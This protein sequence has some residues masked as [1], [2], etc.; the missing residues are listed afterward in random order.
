[1]RSRS[2]I[3]SR[4]PPRA[5]RRINYSAVREAADAIIINSESLRSE[6]TQHLDVD[7]SKFR[8]IYEAVDHRRLQARRR[9]RRTG[10]PRGIRRH[11]AVRALRVVAVAVQELRRS[12]ARLGACAPRARQIISW[13]SSG[14]ARDEKYAARL[15]GLAAELG[16]LDDVVFTGG[17]PLEETVELLPGGR[18]LRVPVVQRDVRA[19]DPRGD[20]VRLPG[21]DVEH[22]CDA[23]DR[24]RR[25]PALRPDRSPPSIARGDRSTPQDRHRTGCA[26]SGSGGPRSSPGRDG[27]GDARR[28]PR[29]RRATTASARSM[30]IL[31]TGGAGFIGSH[32]CDRLARARARRRRARRV[33]AAGALATERRRYLVPTSTSTKATS[34]TATCLRI[35]CVV[36]TRSTTSLRTRTTFPDFSRFSDVNVVSTALIYEII[37]AERLDLARVVVASSQAA[38]GEGLYRCARRRRPAPRDASRDA[39]SPPGTGTCRCP[40]CGGPLGTAGDARAQSRIRRTRTACRSSA[41]RWWPSTSAAATASRRS[42]CATASC[43]GRGS[44]STTRTRGRAASSA[45]VTCRA[46]RRRCTRTAQ[47]IRDYVNIDDVVDANVLVLDDERAVGHVL[48]VGGGEAVTHPRDSPTSSCASTAPS[49]RQSSPASTA[50]AIHATSSRTSPRCAA[51]GW[52][53]QRRPDDSVAAYADWLEGMPGLDGVLDDANERCAR[54]AS[55]GERQ[56]MKAFLLAAGVGSRLRPLTDA[57]PKCMVRD[58][59]PAA[60]RHLARCVRPTRESTRCMVNLHHLARRWRSTSRHASARRSCGSRSSQSCSGAPA[61]SSTIGGGSTRRSSFSSA[62]PTTSPTSMCGRSSTVHEAGRRRRR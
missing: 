52:A 57:I 17:V 51:L 19:S 24:G 43:R 22:E 21:R 62:T 36:S 8:L 1:M 38:M 56:T 42:R 33:D 7:S 54:S 35:F 18:R 44:R 3:R 29:G 16:I 4:R 53:A 48:N 61:R 13:S 60:A 58:R 9:S 41:R 14:P 45:S 46:S 27:R 39:R 28:L 15:R 6:I 5:Y 25:R 32:T 55:S 2:P 20:G 31:V 47:S 10:A 40:V 37:V 12:A 11:E 26:S 49:S 34:A 50:S 59:R 23:G 30:R